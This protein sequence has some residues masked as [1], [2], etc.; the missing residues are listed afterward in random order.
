MNLAQIIQQHIAN[1]P[2]EQQA[3]VLDFVLF[4]EKKLSISV[5]EPIVLCHLRDEPAI[6]IWQERQ[7]M[8]DSTEWVCKVR[9]DVW[10]RQKAVL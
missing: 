7:D 2:P 1:F 5:E 4:L 10:Q 3:E 6:G 8:Q 9:R